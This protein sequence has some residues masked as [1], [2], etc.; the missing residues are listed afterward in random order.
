MNGF[1]NSGVA[2]A[3]DGSRTFSPNVGIRSRVLATVEAGRAV[4]QLCDGADVSNLHENGGTAPPA[5]FGLLVASHCVIS[6]QKHIV[7]LALAR[8]GAESWCTPTAPD[9]CG[10]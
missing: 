10:R 5:T 9:S 7:L 2:V 3:V 4:G 8:G 1:G 6:R